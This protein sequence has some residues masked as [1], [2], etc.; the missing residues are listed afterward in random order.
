M[1]NTGRAALI[2]TLIVVAE[3]S[4]LVAFG[5]QASGPRVLARWLGFGAPALPLQAWA[6]SAAIALAYATASLRGLDSIRGRVFTL[7]ALK[8]LGVLFAFVTGLFEEWFFRKAF[9]DWA[10]AHGCGIALQI[11]ASGLVFGAAHAIWGLFGGNSRTFFTAMAFTGVLGL[12]LGWL[13]IF[14]GRQLAP[15]VWSHIAINLIIEPWLL[16]GVLE[17]RAP[18][19]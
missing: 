19:R 12:A 4:P 1:T 17:L 5:L 6:I 8:L 2:M 3:G 11:L 14:A 9:M 16:L 7:N 10:Q 18:S 15:C 13:Y